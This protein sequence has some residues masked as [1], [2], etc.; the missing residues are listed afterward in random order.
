MRWPLHS[1]RRLA[2]LLGVAA[3]LLWLFTTLGASDDAAPTPS[4]VGNAVTSSTSPTA[5]SAP[6]SSSSSAAS[7]ASAGATSAPA[8]GVASSPGEVA[9]RF[10]TLWARPDLPAEVWRTEVT[11]LATPEFGAQLAT[12]LP[13]NVPARRVVGSPVA[14]SVTELAAAVSVATDA[15]L[16]QVDLAVMSGVWRVSG[17]TPAGPPPTHADGAGSSFAATY[18]PLPG[19]G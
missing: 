11:A 16:V 18:T 4:T 17:L 19:G 13:V 12:V 6:A 15:G 7:T 3:A 8:V 9:V 2:G 14:T 10:V 1:P 5:S